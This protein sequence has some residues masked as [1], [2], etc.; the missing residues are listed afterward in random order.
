[1][2]STGQHILTMDADSVG[3]YPASGGV[4]L[5]PSPQGTADQGLPAK[6]L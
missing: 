3:I 2:T 5:C 1:M 4:V 6:H